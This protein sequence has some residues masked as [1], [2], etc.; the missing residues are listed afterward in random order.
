MDK[1][2]RHQDDGNFFSCHNFIE[3]MILLQGHRGVQQSDKE[4][5]A[6]SSNTFIRR[7]TFH[8]QWDKAMFQVRDTVMTKA[9]IQSLCKWVAGT[10]P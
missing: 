4:Q 1:Q 5:S 3:I 10:F 9:L 6:V 2:E 7:P 8:L